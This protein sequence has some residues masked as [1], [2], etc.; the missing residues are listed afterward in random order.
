MQCH[1]G[2]RVRRRCN[3]GTALS[4]AELDADES[5]HHHSWQ[6]VMDTEHVVQPSAV[7]GLQTNSRPRRSGRSN[8]KAMSAT[9][10]CSNAHVV[11]AMGVTESAFESA[12]QKSGVNTRLRQRQQ[13]AQP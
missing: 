10:M 9:E 5:V 7:G 13:V 2:R 4:S 6:Q 1:N 12:Q 11:G 3:D 8:N